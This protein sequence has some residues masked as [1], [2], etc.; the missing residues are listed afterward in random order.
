MRA[1]LSLLLLAVGALPATAAEPADLIVHN[2]HV[3][4]VDAKFSIAAAVAVGG[5]K[6]L[7][8]G[9]DAAVLKFRAPKTRVIDAKG[10]M[11]LPGLFDSHVHSIDAVTTELANPPPVIRSLKDAFAYIRRQT[12]KLPKG[13]W[14]VLRFAFPTRLDEAR[15]PTKAELDAVAPDHPVLFNAGPASMVNSKALEVSK[16]TKDTPAPTAG[17]IVKD[18]TTGEPTGLL[19][20]ADSKLRGVPRDSQKVSPKARRD[21]VLKMLRL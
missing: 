1:R 17:M 8:V 12:A 7:A 14:V 16:I 5:G 18:P 11:V 2:A 15:F 21:G 4:T 6:V 3:V 19:R 13:D 9:E 10:R 20:N